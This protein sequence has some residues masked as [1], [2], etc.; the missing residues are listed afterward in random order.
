MVGWYEEPADDGQVI[1][2]AGF[3]IA[4]QSV[5]DANE[6]RVVELPER[7]VASVMYRGSM[8]DVEEVYVALLQWIDD[9]GYR[10][11]GRSR[12][13]YL[14]WNDDDPAASVTEIQMPIVK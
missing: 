2:H 9:S 12:E 10:V 14:E 5:E 11:D 4:N 3:D 1:V 13:L 7:L 8:E 6:V